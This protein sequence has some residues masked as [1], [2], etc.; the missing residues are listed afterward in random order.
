MPNDVSQTV[1]LTSG[2]SLPTASPPDIQR[3][4]REDPHR[5]RT[6]IG[7]HDP[8]T[9]GPNPAPTKEQIMSTS[10]SSI[11]IG[12]KQRIGRWVGVSALGALIAI[13]VA[14]III[15]LAGAN[16]R[17]STTAT[18]THPASTYPALSQAPSRDAPSATGYQYLGSAQLHTGARS[19]TT[20]IANPPTTK[21][22][23]CI[24]VSGENRCV[25]R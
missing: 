7:S 13:A 20:T 16:H 22:H 8:Q 4:A 18:H 15:T 21:Q 12:P 1:P 24:F 23:T 5:A 3:G 6:V 10:P 11:Q 25:A 14:V 2:P 17:T 9:Q 19:A